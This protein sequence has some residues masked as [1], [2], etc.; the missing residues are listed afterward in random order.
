ML[1]HWHEAVPNDRLAHLIKD[2]SRAFLRALQNRLARHDIP[3]GIWTFLRILWERDGLTQRDI[4]LAA[5][6][7]EPTTV[8]ALRAM[9]ARGYVVRKQKP[10]N[11][12][13]IYVFLT[14]AGR[15]LESTLIPLAE[16][17]NAVAVAGID[18]DVVAV[19]RD[20]LLA[21]IGNLARDEIASEAADLRPTEPKIVA[22]HRASGGTKQGT[23]SPPARYKMNTTDGEHAQLTRH[24]SD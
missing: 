16:E 12:K 3:L 19:T 8:T 5:G 6:V 21:M 10:G 24:D 9:E 11:R 20:S 14:P 18:P 17:V 15:S 13:N 1:R 7:M 23:T 4:S 2:A 22:K